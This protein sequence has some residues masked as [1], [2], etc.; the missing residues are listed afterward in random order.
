MSPRPCQSRTCEKERPTRRSGGRDRSLRHPRFSKRTTCRRRRISASTGLVRLSGLPGTRF[1]ATLNQRSP[2][3]LSGADSLL[4]AAP[5]AQR[6]SDV[7]GHPFYGIRREAA[8]AV[9]ISNALRCRSIDLGRDDFG[10]RRFWAET[11]LGRDDFGRE[12]AQRFR[13]GSKM[14]ALLDRW[15]VARARL[16]KRTPARCLKMV[17]RRAPH[18][19]D[20][21]RPRAACGD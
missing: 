14:R 6:R 5:M 12:E 18:H 13:K 2:S 10:P 16:Q 7:G 8:R 4:L 21:S 11:I 20:P 9:K 19:D 1:G 17:R 15:A 3:R